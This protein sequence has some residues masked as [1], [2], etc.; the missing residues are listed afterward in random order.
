MKHRTR[1]S[2]QFAAIGYVQSPFADRFAVPRQPG[3]AKSVHGVLKLDSDPD[4]KTALKTLDQFSHLWVIFVF[5]QHGAR[6]WKP[7]VRPPR[8]GGVKKVGVL[9]SRSP[10]RPNPIGISVVTIERMDLEAIGGPE[11]TVGG[12]DLI[13]GTPILDLK[14]YLAF[15]DAV[16]EADAGW[17]KAEWT[18][19]KITFCK[20]AEADVQILDPDGTRKLREQIV[21]LLAMDPRP[22]FQKRQKPLGLRE[23][24]GSRYGFDIMNF[25]VKY[26]LRDGGFTV[27]SVQSSTD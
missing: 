6:D 8:L 21:E 1:E 16:P 9:A 12:L 7:S 19:A 13:D 11:I 24:E 5:H 22:A 26:E 2:F 25:D 27:L 23:S 14:P 17:A 18:L 10:H 4:L 15:V 20:P 3:L